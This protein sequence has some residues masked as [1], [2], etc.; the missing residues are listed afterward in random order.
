MKNTISIITLGIFLFTIVSCKK[1]SDSPTTTTQKG[2]LEV[3][4][5]GQKYTKEKDFGIIT[6]MGQSQLCDGKTGV[7][8][9]HIYIGS[10]RFNLTT[11]LVHFRNQS[12]FASSKS[13]NFQL[14]DDWIYSNMSGTKICNLALE[15]KLEDNSEISKI[16]S[17][18]I[19]T[20]KSINKHS[21]DNSKVQYIVEGTFSG[22]YRNKSNVTYPVS[23]SYR[24]LV[25]VLK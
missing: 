9:Y 13:G 20:V 11:T 3:S 23:G 22:N 6:Q 17:N 12:D 19:H 5:D 4:I 1:D 18:P 2:F 24:V 25:Q 21:E 16:V 10:S 8:T 14:T 15:V 7:G